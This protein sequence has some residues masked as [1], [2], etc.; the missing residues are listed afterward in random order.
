M[1]HSA[2]DLIMAAAD[3]A[4]EAGT[5]TRRQRFTLGVL[6]RAMPRR[7]RRW[8]AAVADELEPP[9]IAGDDRSGIDPDVFERLLQLLIEYLPKLLEI[10]L[11]L[12]SKDDD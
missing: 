12:F 1:A 11:P 6:R 5:V 3:A 8:A 7:F 10:L 2:V 9:A 4:V